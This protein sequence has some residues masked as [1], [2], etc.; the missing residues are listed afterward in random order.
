MNWISWRN[1]W[2]IV[3]LFHLRRRDGGV[4]L[5]PPPLSRRELPAMSIREQLVKAGGVSGPDSFE[6]P[7]VS[8]LERVRVNFCARPSKCGSAGPAAALAAASAASGAATAATTATASAVAVASEGW[9]LSGME[10]L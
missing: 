7:A 2:L 4:S 3:Y 1:V 5:S 8:E 10:L 6:L 9:A